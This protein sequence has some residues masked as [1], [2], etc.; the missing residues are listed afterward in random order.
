MKLIL[1]AVLYINTQHISAAFLAKERCV[2]ALGKLST[3]TDNELTNSREELRHSL[4]ELYRNVAMSE[5]E[6][7][8]NF[9]R[10]LEPLHIQFQQLKKQSRREGHYHCIC[11]KYSKKFSEIPQTLSNECAMKYMV[12]GETHIQK[13]I[14]KLEIFKKD[15]ILLENYMKECDRK[16]FLYVRSCYNNL[17]TRIVHAQTYIPKRIKSAVDLTKEDISGND[18][19]LKA[20]YSEQLQQ[21]FELGQSYINQ[22]SKDCFI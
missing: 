16:F 22:F 20:C 10:K 6:K 12:E 18:I 14:G 2:Q 8:T 21:A 13:E 4:S 7:P 11:K 19:K 3:I 17:L 9:K 1:L 15:V 5:L